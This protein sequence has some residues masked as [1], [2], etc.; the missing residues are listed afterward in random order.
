MHLSNTIS[1]NPAG[2]LFLPLVAAPDIIVSVHRFAVGCQS[3]VQL[4][5]YQVHVFQVVFLQMKMRHH[6]ADI[7]SITMG[8]EPENT[9]RRCFSADFLYL[10]PFI[11]LLAD[12]TPLIEVGESFRNGQEPKQERK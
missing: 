1:S 7:K 8:S 10:L 11:Q 5:L 9:Q 2:L 3:F 6:R 12:I 4:L